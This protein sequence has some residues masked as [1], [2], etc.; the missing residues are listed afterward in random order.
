M[1]N[2]LP[3]VSVC[4]PNYNYGHYLEFCFES[5]LEQ[6]YPNFEVSFSDNASTDDSYE[7]AFR[8]RK[9]FLEKGIYFRLNDN[10]RNLGSNKNS[11]I[12]LNRSEGDF[13]HYLASDDAIAPTF[14]EKCMSVFINNPEVGTVITHREEIDETG[15]IYQTPPF[16]NTSCIIDGESQAA[17]Y[18]M[19]GIAV[20]G[21]RMV[22]RDIFRKTDPYARDFTIAGDWFFNFLYTMAG[23]VAYINEPL[24]KYRVH[25]DNETSESERKLQGVFEHY[26]LINAFVDISEAFGM[27]KPAARYDEAVKKLSGMCLRYALKMFKAGLN[28][29]GVRYLKLAPVFTLEIENNDIYKQL[30]LYVDAS[31]SERAKIL[32]YV[33]KSGI[34]ARSTSYDPPEGFMPITVFS[35]LEKGG[36]P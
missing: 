28:D 1:Y 3:L 6:T 10:K 31:K 12:A 5:L 18:M 16:Y 4:I 11:I 14:I 22:R 32:T 35:L 8:Y 2:K 36:K 23:D 7:I 27:K 30:L 25:S 13:I 29:I 19:A 20:P 33:E 17:V 24:F 9:K 21:Q 34:A 26:Q 15:K